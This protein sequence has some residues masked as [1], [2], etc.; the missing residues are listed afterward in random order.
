HETWFYKLC[1]WIDKRR[2]RHIYVRIDKW[3]TWSMDHTLAHI[4]LPMLKQLNATKHG[5]PQVDDSDVPDELKSTNAEPKQ[6]EYDVDGNHFKRWDWI[7]GEMIWTFE[8]QVKDDD[9]DEFYI[10]PTERFSS[11]QKMIENIKVDRE[12]LDKHQ[13][14]KANGFRL[15]GKYYQALWD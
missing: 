8:Q 3:D 7:L 9:T 10:H 4:I 11:L 5:A 1:N 13:A 14:R 2:S 6:D 15:F 12:G